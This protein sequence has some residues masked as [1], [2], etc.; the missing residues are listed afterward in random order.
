MGSEP[1][2]STIRYAV[3]DRVLTITFDRA[4]R[5]NTVNYPML[6]ELLEAFDCAAA[7]DRIRVFVVA[8]DGEFFSAGTDLST[9]SGGYDARFGLPFTQRGIVPESCATWF[10]PRIVGI[11]TAVDW[12]VTGRLFPAA[13]AHA[14]GLVHQLFPADQVLDRAHE[15]AAQIMSTTSA[16]SVALTRQLMWRQLGSPH[17]M[18]ANR[19]ESKALIALGQMGDAKEGVA[20]FKEKRAAAFPLTVADLPDFYPWWADEPFDEG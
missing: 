12:S 14:G 9:G 2:F 13:E 20:A 5:R 18:S 16:V 10:L 7:D 3:H 4:E 6:D 19:L 15:L 8:G 11:A 17:P 1:N